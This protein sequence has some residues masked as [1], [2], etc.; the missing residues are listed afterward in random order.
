[1]S[2]HRAATKNVS[3]VDV[4]GSPVF[5]PRTLV[6]AGADFPVSPRQAEHHGEHGSETWSTGNTEGARY[7]SCPPWD[8]IDP[9]L[10]VVTRR[11]SHASSLPA[12]FEQVDPAAGARMRGTGV[13]IQPHAEPRTIGQPKAPIVAA[14]TRWGIHEIVQPWVG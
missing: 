1:M 8:T 12:G 13:V 5:R 14:H 2:C 3:G 11:R 6:A 10:A 9:V 7:K 4:A